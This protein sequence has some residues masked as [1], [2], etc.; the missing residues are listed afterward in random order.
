MPQVVAYRDD[1]RSGVL[2]KSM[3][4]RVASEPYVTGLRD[5][6]NMVPT[7]TGSM[8]SV[9]GNYE[10]HPTTGVSK[11]AREEVLYSFN[12]VNKYRIVFTEDDAQAYDLEDPL[13]APLTWEGGAS[14]SMLEEELYEMQVIQ[15]RGMLW[16]VH[17]NHAPQTI[18][19]SDA[20]PGVLT[21][22]VPTIYTGVSTNYYDGTWHVPDGTVSF[23]TTGNY[24][25]V[26]GYH[27]TRLWFACTDNNPSTVWGSRQLFN[28]YMQ[29]DHTKALFTTTAVSVQGDGIMLQESS[30]LGSKIAFIESS[31]RIIV[32]STR[33]IYYGGSDVVSAVSDSD[34]GIVEFDLVLG[35]TIGAHQMRPVT[36]A[37]SILFAGPGRRSLY[38]AQW[39]QQGFAAV[40]VT[41][42]NPSILRPKVRSMAVMQTPIPI[43][44]MTL[45]DGSGLALSADAA[46]GV[47]GFSPLARSNM[48][49]DGNTVTRLNQ[50]VSVYYTDD[51][52][53]ILWTVSE[54]DSNDVHSLLQAPFDPLL[55]AMGDGQPHYV[56]RGGYV[57]YP[58]GASTLLFA[59]L[60]DGYEDVTGI[61][62]WADYA[63]L[64]RSDTDAAGIVLA[65]EVIDAHYGLPIEM[66]FSPTIPDVPVQGTGQAQVRGITKVMLR[67]VD[68]YGG[69]AG[70]DDDNLS[71]L[72]YLYPGDYMLGDPLPAMSGD[73][74][75]DTYCWNDT[76]VSVTVRQTIPAP[77]E[78]AAVILWIA[79]TEVP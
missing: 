23:S 78:V 71:E 19:L 60:V 39:S 70:P 35:A 40:D 25:A 14:F 68:S 79:V 50:W 53:R 72:V 18:Y 67:L 33:A 54:S 13:G 57:Q 69:A 55:D 24:P 42:F 20:T 27:N 1:F 74:V 76:D 26:V 73:F 75:V 52:D 56:D 49:R 17:H 48:V 38:A 36:A 44:W 16:I 32:G 41:R 6:L 12:G 58:S 31:A 21:L 29:F 34:L 43:V 28:G 8:V 59:D 9:P 45:D 3:L 11:I 2:S 64:P 5:S 77:I 61:D 37:G 7:K 4:A 47:T 51:E 10:L 66:H 22:T 15:L 46:S 63:P 65:S 30:M 62:V